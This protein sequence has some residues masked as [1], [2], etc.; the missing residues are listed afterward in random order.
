MLSTNSTVQTRKSQV[1][2]FTIKQLNFFYPLNRVFKKY[3]DLSEIQNKQIK[4]ILTFL[5]E[6]VG[7]GRPCYGIE[8]ALCSFLNVQSAL[9]LF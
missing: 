5:M 9:K 8:A 1:R 4:Y 2:V 6:M 3:L 7:G